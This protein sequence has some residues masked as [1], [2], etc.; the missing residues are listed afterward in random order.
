VLSEIALGP[1]GGYVVYRARGGDPLPE[2]D[3]YIAPMSDPAN[4]KIFL[5][6]SAVEAA[7][8]VS[9]AGTSLAYQ[10]DQTG[11]METYLRPLPGPG[12]ATPVSI[13]GG[14][15]PMWSR[16]G[17]T[18]YYRAPDGWIMAA[19]VDQAR[20]RVLDRRRVFRD[21]YLSLPAHQNYDVF[22]NGDF[23]FIGRGPA[24]SRVAVTTDWKR[25]LTRR[26]GEDR[27]F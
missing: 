16:D 5:A 9:P 11:R 15:E 13:N 22:P 17:K 19:A 12:A 10:S 27:P 8:R 2:T 14:I 25:L 18:L 6:T 26:S 1:A 24:D 23:L 7:P 3:L 4:M 20:Q 21:G